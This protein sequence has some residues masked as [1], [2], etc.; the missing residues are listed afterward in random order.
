[1]E[2][3]NLK[4]MARIGQAQTAPQVM[5]YCGGE[6][7]RL[8]VS[9]RSYHLVERF[10]SQV[11]KGAIILGAG[12]PADWLQR[13][14]NPEF[15]ANDP[16]PDYIMAAGNVTTWQDAIAAQKLTPAQQSFVQTMQEY[17]L[18]FGVG[19]PLFGPQGS[20]AY[21]SFSLGRQMV[22]EDMPLM[23]WLI[24]IAQTGHRRVVA[25][26]T[27]A[28]VPPKLSK[29]EIEVLHW[30]VRGK[31]VRDIATIIDRSPATVETFIKRLYV[32]LKVNDRAGA[33]IIALRLGIVKL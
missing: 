22:P 4:L 28:N 32:K 7:G 14:H 9:L 26:T 16:I 10:S 15:R 20:D 8:G 13:Y 12:F 3:V 19:C 5:S 18:I 30:L 1:M 24:T 23:H 21:L 2:G 6:F 31:S 29:R 33:I 27:E 25:L 17:G 11:G